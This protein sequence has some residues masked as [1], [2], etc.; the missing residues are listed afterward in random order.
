M[1]QE[2]YE[3][4]MAMAE[5]SKANVRATEAT[6]DRARLYVDFTRVTSPLTGRISRRFVDPGNLINADNT[7]LTTIVTENPLYAYFDVDERT[8]LDLVESASGHSSWLTGLQFPVLMSLANE[9]KEGETVFAR[10]GTVNFIDNRVIATTGTIRMRAV[11][12]NPND[13]LKSGLFVRIRLPIGSP[14]H[15]LLIPDEAI[16]SDQGR[17]YV[18][19]VNDQNAVEYRAVKPGQAIQKLRVIKEGLAESDRVLITGMQRVRQ[20]AQV[21][22]TM[23]EPAQAPESPLTR[24]L[25]KARKETNSR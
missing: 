22:A 20:K 2:D 7:V 25:H 1:A 8:Y 16:L 4:A 14:Y 23:K 6:R 18:Y 24:L 15:T 12:E 13:L 3:T 10:D 5:K 9:N 21:Q 11:F 17:K 19:I